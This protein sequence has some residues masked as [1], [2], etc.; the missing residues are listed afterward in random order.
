[1][2]GIYAHNFA[3]RISEDELTERLKPEDAVCV[4]DCTNQSDAEEDLYEDTSEEG[5][6]LGQIQMNLLDLEVERREGLSLRDVADET[7]IQEK[8]SVQKKKS[9]VRVFLMEKEQWQEAIENLRQKLRLLGTWEDVGTFRETPI[10]IGMECNSRH[11]LKEA[12]ARLIAKEIQASKYPTA[13]V[14]EFW[15]SM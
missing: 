3:N 1:M 15:V 13:S 7:T 14:V 5:D 8:I 4:V 11:G 12:A 2:R 6:L 10:C 9:D